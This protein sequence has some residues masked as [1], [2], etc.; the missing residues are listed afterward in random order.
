MPNDIALTMNC[1]IVSPDKLLFEGSIIKA[2][3]PGFRQ[4]LA[5]LPDHTPLYTQLVAGD[6]IITSTNQQTKTFP[7]ESGIA[8][9][10]AN[11]LTIITGFDVRGNVLGSQSL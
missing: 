4:V 9:V 11:T 8:R 2:I 10:R 3:I 7:I 6:I 1:A 5:I